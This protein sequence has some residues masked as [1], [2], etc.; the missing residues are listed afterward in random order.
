[1]RPSVQ[2]LT[3]TD[4][5]ISPPR[6]HMVDEKPC[7]ILEQDRT[8]AYGKGR[9]I[10]SVYALDESHG[11]ASCNGRA[12]CDHGGASR[13]GHRIERSDR[14]FVHGYE[15]S[16]WGA[17]PQTTRDTS[18]D[19][20]LARG[21]S[22]STRVSIAPLK[23]SDSEFVDGF[24]KGTLCRTAPPVVYG[25]VVL[26]SSSDGI[27]GLMDFLVALGIDA[28][29]KATTAWALE[30]GATSLEELAEKRYILAEVLH[31]KPLEE[32]RLFRRACEIAKRLTSPQ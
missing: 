3:P 23:R 25:S 10:R 24:G 29:V 9:T 14:N 20:H 18:V 27:P 31:L 19:C 13:F 16:Q 1:M 22:G 15:A 28:Y 12:E 2:A 32:R 26:P 6:A 17:E 21:F 4:G 11:F 7:K 30:M 5:T 8:K